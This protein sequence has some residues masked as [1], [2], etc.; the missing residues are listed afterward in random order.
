MNTA[1]RIKYSMNASQKEP[2]H[3]MMPVK[4]PGYALS[5]I[6]ARTKVDA[7]NQNPA[8]YQGRHVDPAGMACNPLMKI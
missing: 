1:I 2:I 3:V 8:I 5:K 4:S 6:L 7:I